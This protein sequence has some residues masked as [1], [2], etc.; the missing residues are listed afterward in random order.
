MTIMEVSLLTGFYPNQD[1][2]KQLT[3]DVEMYAFQYETKTSSSDS[4][5]VLYLEKLSHK[6]NTVLGFRVHRMLTAEFLQAAHVTV[7]DY[8]EPWPGGAEPA[9]AEPGGHPAP[10]NAGPSQPQALAPLAARRCSS[11]YNLPAERSSLRKIC[12]KDVCRCAEE[13]CPSRRRH[14]SPMRQEEFQVAAC[15]AG[16]DF[17]YKARLETVEASP[18]N[19]YVYYNMRL[20]V[21]IKS[22]TDSTRPLAVKKFVSHATCHDSLGL[23]EQETY[24]IM[25]QTSDLWR[26]KS[27]YTYVLGK[28]TFLMRW[29]AS[30]DVGKKELLRQLEGF[31]EYMRTHGCEF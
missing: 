22:G 30:G 6:E 26:V 23:R 29:P 2:L 16:V 24:L 1:D 3:S 14:S 27:D 10:R 12:H 31:S 28:E 5:V 25:G 19:P 17:V 9:G 4:A 13:Q 8:Y 11:F 15:E 18:S 21:I 20:Q 7:Y